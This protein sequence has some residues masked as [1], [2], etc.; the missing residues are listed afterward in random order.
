MRTV[1]LVA[2]LCLT[3]TAAFAECI[4]V[5][6]PAG[7]FGTTQAN[8][9]YSAAS[10]CYVLNVAVG[11]TARVWIMDSDDVVFDVPDLGNGYR[12]VTFQ[13]TSTY[14]DVYTERD[15]DTEGGV[16]YRIGF[17]IR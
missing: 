13:T 17:D 1:F 12:D 5:E 15:S 2:G 11:Q 16:A 9:A 10:N 3:T 8:T 14:L 4:E 6:F 7:S